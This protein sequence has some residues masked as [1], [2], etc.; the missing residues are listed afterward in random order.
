VAA[1][2]FGLDRLVD[3]R[4]NGLTNGVGAQKE[5]VRSSSRKLS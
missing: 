5:N 1:N 2:P 4:N 3:S